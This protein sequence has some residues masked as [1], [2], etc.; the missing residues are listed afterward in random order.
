MVEAKEIENPLKGKYRI[1][2]AVPTNKPT[3][4]IQTNQQEG[5]FPAEDSSLN[6]QTNK[7]TNKHTNKS[8]DELV[9]ESPELNDLLIESESSSSSELPF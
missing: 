5:L 9:K 4:N 8:W 3:T 2:N 1:H 7:L 6:Q